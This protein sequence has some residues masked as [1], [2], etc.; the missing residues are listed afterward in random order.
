MI[1]L[2]EVEQ[3]SNEL[4]KG[5]MGVSRDHLA[6]DISSIVYRIDVFDCGDASIIDRHID[7]EYSFGEYYEVCEDTS[8]FQFICTLCG[9]PF[10]QEENEIIIYQKDEDES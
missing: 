10:L 2:N 3:I 7:I 6:E 4:S 5:N 9:L 8:L 1:T